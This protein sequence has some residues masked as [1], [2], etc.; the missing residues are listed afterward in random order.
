MGL[1]IVLGLSNFHRDDRDRAA[2]MLG[3][4]VSAGYCSLVHEVVDG[5]VLQV[6][7]GR[8]VA[9]VRW[10]EPTDATARAIL[11]DTD[12]LSASIPYDLVPV[13]A[14]LHLMRLSLP[15]RKRGNFKLDLPQ[16]PAL[17]DVRCSSVQEVGGWG[18][19]KTA[20]KVYH[21]ADRHSLIVHAE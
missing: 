2:S 12:G 4:I 8:G 13:M 15:T 10:L 20:Q 3:A 17:H 9:V 6:K 19:Y 18:R 16:Q 21:V 7:K 14:R 1:S 5:A 11:A